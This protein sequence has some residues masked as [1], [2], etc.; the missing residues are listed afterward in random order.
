MDRMGGDGSIA[1][2]ADPLM[3]GQTPPNINM[4]GIF[5]PEMLAM[6]EAKAGEDRGPMVLAVGSVFM[7]LSIIVVALR[8]YTRG[9][10]QCKL[11]IDDYLMAFGTVWRFSLVYITTT[12]VDR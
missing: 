7:S 3:G 1:I 10:V 11:G 12:T 5:S 6:M 8:L 4:T 9:V 2:P